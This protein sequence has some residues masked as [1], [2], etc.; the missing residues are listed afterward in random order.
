MFNLHNL[1]KLIFA[2]IFLLIVT[3]VYTFFN[4]DKTK[5]IN[6]DNMPDLSAAY[7]AEEEIATATK[8]LQSSSLRPAT[9]VTHNVDNE[10]VIA[11]TLDGL[12]RKATVERLLDVL[13]KHNAEAAFFVE[14][15]NAAGSKESVEAIEGK[16]HTIGNYTYIGLA[17]LD[18]AIPA[19]AIKQLC[20]G[21]KVLSVTGNFTPT[22]FK[23]PKTRYDLPLLRIA[24]ACGLESAVKTDYFL[25]GDELSSVEAATKAVAAIKPGSIVSLV[26]NR[27]IEVITQKEGIIDDKPAFD[28]KPSLQLQP[29]TEVKHQDVVEA[30]DNLLTACKNQG[31][32]VVPLKKLRTVRLASTESFGSKL[33]QRIALLWDFRLQ[34]IA[35]AAEPYADLRKRNGG[36][37][38]EEIKYV[39]T[40]EQAVCFAFVGFSKPD[41]VNV[42]LDRLVQINSRGTFFVDNRDINKNPQLIERILRE[43]HELGIAIYAKKSGSF[44]SV[45]RDIE[46]TQKLLKNKYGVET[47]LVKQPWGAIAD[48]TKEAVSAMGC[49]LVSQNVNV[50]Q[51]RHKDY[52]NALDI[53]PELFGRFVYSVGRGWIINF[54]MDYYTKPDLCADI[55]Q[56]IKEQKIDNI[57]YWSFDDD[58]ERNPYNDSAYKVKPLGEVMA[59]QKYT[60][61]LPA[62]NIPAHLQYENNR[63]VADG[64]TLHDYISKRYIGTSTVNINS[65]TLGL[66][67]ENLRHLDTSGVVH[68]NKPVVFFSF[69]DWGTDAPINHLLYVFRKHKVKGS[70]FIL[71]HNI[72]NNP[73]L[74]R[75][76]AAEGHDIACHTYTHRPFAVVGKHGQ[77]S[78]GQSREAAFDDLRT[79]YLELVRITGDVQVDGRYSLTRYFRPPTLTVSKIGFEE[80]YNNGYDYIISGSTSTH[81]YE[82]QS[83]YEMIDSIRV[84]LY[85][86]GRVIKGATFVMHMSD[87]SKYTARA[88]DILLIKNEK[89]DDNDPTKF[90]VGRLSDYLIDGYDQSN[91]QATLKLQEA[92]GH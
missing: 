16:C 36:V 55:M 76:I 32:E 18:K 67:Q 64:E 56:L 47:N 3:Y 49:K 42:V 63:M 86:D 58:P 65:N 15:S 25:S 88:L 5:Y 54:R 31:I 81:D 84:G 80:L 13:E 44:A 6:Y 26:I 68:T 34:G 48:Y 17:K 39:L 41:D 2:V 61:S 59:N 52:T 71:A 12:P 38:A 28:K 66:T 75:A 30:L 4:E 22:L 90:M 83:L 74:L 57:A 50:V 35:Y 8:K 10:M 78:A 11:L 92:N 27:P 46:T 43:G 40:T 69:D 20:M 70:F 62:T 29:K 87:A 21:Q 1:V 23:A 85:K 24:S 51:S 89:K 14:G 77:L 60:Y 82:A 9:V 37:Q 45:C 73:N 79:A 33:A 91:R 72:K 19:E 53:L 7:L